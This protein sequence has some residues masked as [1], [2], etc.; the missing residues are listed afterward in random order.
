MGTK[1]KTLHAKEKTKMPL[2][3]CRFCGKKVPN[4]FHKYHEQ[5]QCVVAR[6]A[7]GEYV[8]PQ[9]KRRHVKAEKERL[10]KLG[11]EAR[12]RPQKTLKRWVDTVPTRLSER[13]R[14]KCQGEN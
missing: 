4:I 7:R 11:E 6:K 1:S 5:V 9:A 12:N 10:R 13:K 2:S 8:D 3:K 14:S